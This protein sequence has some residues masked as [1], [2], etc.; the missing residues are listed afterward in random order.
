MREVVN[1]IADILMRI[2]IIIAVFGAISL[3]AKCA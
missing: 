3:I 2:G 1:A